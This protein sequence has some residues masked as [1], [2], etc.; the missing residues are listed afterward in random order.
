MK[1]SQWI[2]ILAGIVLA[3]ACFLPWTFHPD[4]NKEFTGFFSENNAYGKPGKVFIALAVA[5]IAFYLVP[6]LWAKRCN[7]FIVAVTMAYSIK[8]F[9]LFTGCYRGICPEKRMGVWIM[10]LAPAVML[11]MALLVPDIRK[12]AKEEGIS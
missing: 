5:A 9:I 4:L 7:F 12:A 10:L 2:G 8:T 1:Y 3:V 6:R 11:A